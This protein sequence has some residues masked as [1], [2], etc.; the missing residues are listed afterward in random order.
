M[1]HE[2]DRV[3]VPANGHG[4]RLTETLTPAG[5]DAAP[6]AKAGPGAE[7]PPDVTESTPAFTPTQ[8]AVGFGIVASL[9][10]LIAGR[11]RRGRRS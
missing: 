5:P 7:R 1:S 9:I 8:L 2:T 6:T 10:L 11:R 3:P 4:P